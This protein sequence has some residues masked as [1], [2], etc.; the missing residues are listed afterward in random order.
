MRKLNV[1]IRKIV[2]L[3]I[4][5][6]ILLTLVVYISDYLPSSDMA[7]LI[8]R[9]NNKQPIVKSVDTVVSENAKSNLPKDIMIHKVKQPLTQN[10]YEAEF[11]DMLDKREF[12]RTFKYTSKNEHK[13]FDEDFKVISHALHSVS[14]KHPEYM[15]YIGEIN[16]KIV[17][18]GFLSEL[19]IFLNPKVDLENNKSIGEM[20]DV[21]ELQATS[22]IE[23]LKQEG[24]ISETQTEKEKARVLYTWVVQ[25]TKYKN[26]N[27]I[28]TFSGYGQMIN[29][30]AVCQGYVSSYN[31]L[32]RLVGIENVKGISGHVDGEPH[33]WTEAILDGERVLI[34]VTFGDPLPD[35]GDKVDY[36]YFDINEM[37]LRKTHSW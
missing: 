36:K 35:R 28:E 13:N 26:R 17:N 19:T 5:V 29:G 1:F 27:S 11:L 14:S 8:N 32:L 10:H 4:V 16:T 18:N 22:V 34:D 15:G 9:F 3:S 24:K 37:E 7:V 30:E 6:T 23:E 21:F 31:Y 12:T 33:I 2:I 25:N 20:L